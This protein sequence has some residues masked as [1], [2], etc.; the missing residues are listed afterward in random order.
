MREQKERQKR[1]GHA[2]IGEASRDPPVDG[3]VPGV[4]RAPADLGQAGVKQVRADGGRRMDS[5]DQHQKRRHQGPAANPGEP[6]KQPDHEPGNGKDR[7]YA[8]HHGG[9]SLDGPRS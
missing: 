6:D 3:A 9:S 2:P 7:I 4:H 8:M 5:E 1:G